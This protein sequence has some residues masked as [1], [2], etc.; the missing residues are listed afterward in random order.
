MTT[1]IAPKKKCPSCG[2]KGKHAPGCTDAGCEYCGMQIGH[3]DEC[4]SNPERATRCEAA[5]EDS[6]C[7]K[8]ASADTNGTMTWGYP[9]DF[10]EEEKAEA[11]SEFAT[12]VD[13]K[14]AKVVL[15]G[16]SGAVVDGEQQ[17]LIKTPL[18]DRVRAIAAKRRELV[19]AEIEKKRVSE[20]VKTIQGELNEMV[21]QLVQ[22]V[23][24]GV[25]T[26]P[27]KLDASSDDDEGEETALTGAERR[28]LQMAQEPAGE[29]GEGKQIATQPLSTQQPGLYVTAEEGPEE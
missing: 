16:T 24:D 13:G 7:D 29:T 27:L 1:T 14:E 25:Q 11:S 22:Q 15:D 5:I 8:D 23:D 21:D 10:T 6:R 19:E 3:A 26:L 20:R 28:A 18:A 12:T 9:D 17:E 4:P 2:L